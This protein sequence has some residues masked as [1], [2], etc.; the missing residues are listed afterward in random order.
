[1]HKLISESIL[2]N[3]VSADIMY[4]KLLLLMLCHGLENYFTKNTL[5]FSSKISSS[6]KHE[7][8]DMAV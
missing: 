8:K 3:W 4:T 5:F 7:V 1:M 6:C 2:R